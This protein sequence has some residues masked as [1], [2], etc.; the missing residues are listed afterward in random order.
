L[1]E[2]QKSLLVPCLFPFLDLAPYLRYAEAGATA[3]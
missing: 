1:I 3:L 2:E